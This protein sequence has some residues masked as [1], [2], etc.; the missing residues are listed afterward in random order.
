MMDYAQQYLQ[1]GNEIVR[2]VFT[3]PFSDCNA[4]QS[5]QNGTCLPGPLFKQTL[6]HL[7]LFLTRRADW[8]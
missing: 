2:Q 5:N 3:L 1:P 7:E 4:E 6:P 8:H